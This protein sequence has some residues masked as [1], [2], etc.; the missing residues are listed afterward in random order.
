MVL[1]AAGT[2]RSWIRL[3]AAYWFTMLAAAV[4]MFG[5]AITVQGLAAALLPHRLFLR[6][7][8]FLQ[9]G[10]FCLVVG[11]YFLQPMGVNPSSIVDAQRHGFLSSPSFWFLGLLQACS[12]S[13]ALAAL[14]RPAWVALG[15]T[16]AGMVIAYGLAYVRTLRR[17][18]EE[19]DITPGVTRFRWLPRFG[20]AFPT[21]IVQF[22]LRTL[23][24]SSQHRVLLAFYWGIGFAL[25]ALF[26]K[27]PRAQQTESAAAGWQEG[28]IPL[29]VTSI[30]MTGCAV[31]AARLAFS[32]PLDLPANWIFRTVPIP[33]S[34][35]CVRA[36]RRAMAVVSVLPVW[37]VSAIVFVRN[38]PAGP[39]IVHLGALGLFGLILVELSLRGTQKIPFTCAYL[40]G[41]SRIHIAVYV[42][43][44]LLVPLTFAAAEIERDVIQSSSGA[45]LL[46][47]GLLAVWAG[48]CWQ[49]I[50][51]LDAGDP[52][53]AFE[54]EPAERILTLEVWDSR[55]SSRLESDY[56]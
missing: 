53:P 24:R 3:L 13:P 8:S 44:A 31:M 29:I 54:E 37:M 30:W 20:S 42:A 28:S 32:L 38:W 36:R 52:E 16:T 40:P 33:G 56:R 10:A 22:S 26:L 6:A 27:T 11:G 48:V 55:F 1:P 14:A 25:T 41:K 12:G 19:P 50:R 5:L 45:A 17:M 9:L 47:G 15:L 4:F 2:V 34:R 51:Q 49:A 23:F 43:L 46:L 18:A 35:W 7:S 21:A 39:A